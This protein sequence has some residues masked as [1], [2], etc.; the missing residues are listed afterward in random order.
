MKLD[1]VLKTTFNSKTT[2]W[3]ITI[4]LKRK[5]FLMKKY[6]Q[7]KIINSAIV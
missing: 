1:R 6:I 5:F 2:L 3:D 7:L 4:K